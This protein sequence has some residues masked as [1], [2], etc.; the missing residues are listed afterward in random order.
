MSKLPREKTYETTHFQKYGVWRD[1][2]PT[3]TK[4]L[5]S[6]SDETQFFLR[7]VSKTNYGRIACV[8]RFSLFCSF[9]LPC[10]ADGKHTTTRWFDYSKDYDTSQQMWFRSQLRISC[11][12]RLVFRSSLDSR[13]LD[14]SD[15]FFILLK[16]FLFEYTLTPF[17]SKADST[18][19]ISIGDLREW[20]VK[21]RIEINK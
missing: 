5:H 15:L 8:Y 14:L 19:K 3:A 18:R 9:S 16:F 7:K 17:R 4:N 13:I 2:F 10:R 1:S 20:F 6:D 12:R 21:K 11:L